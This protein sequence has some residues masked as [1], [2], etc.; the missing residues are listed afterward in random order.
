M[1]ELTAWQTAHEQAVREGQDHYTD[2]ET[3][4]RV[5]TE[6]FHRRRGVCCGTG[7]RHCPFDHI[8]VGLPID[9]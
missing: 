7:C 5:F 8:N 3:G 2:P 1:I 9:D 6:V 4:F